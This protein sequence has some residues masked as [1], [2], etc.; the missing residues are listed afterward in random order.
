VQ[1]THARFKGVSFTM[2]TAITYTVSP[3][4]ALLALCWALDGSR[5]SAFRSRVWLVCS[6]LT[7]VALMLMGIAG[8]IAK[9]E[10]PILPFLISKELLFVNHLLCGLVVICIV[11]LKPS[12]AVKTDE[13]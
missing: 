5:S 3:V 13:N 12:H 10:A 7:I 9:N 4:V 11:C 6:N 8:I 2:L 1:K